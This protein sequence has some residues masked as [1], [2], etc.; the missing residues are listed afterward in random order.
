MLDMI[1]SYQNYL[2]LDLEKGQTDLSSMYKPQFDLKEMPFTYQYCTISLVSQTGV[3]N[4][5]E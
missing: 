1:I 3:F 4:E 2:T 5:P